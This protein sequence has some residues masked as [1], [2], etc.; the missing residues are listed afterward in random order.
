MHNQTEADSQSILNTSMQ[1]RRTFLK[2]GAVAGAGLLLPLQGVLTRSNAAIP[3][4]SLRPG[5][6]PKYV[7]ALAVPPAMPRAGQLM[8]NGAPVDYYEVAMRQFN[9]HILPPS[10]GIAPTTVWGYGAANAPASFAYP[11]CT[12]EAKANRPVRV[13][14]VNDLIDNKGRFRKHLLAVDQTLHWAN[15]PGGVNGRDGRGSSQLPYT[16]PVPMVPHLHGAH[17]QDHSDGYAEAWFLPAAANVPAGYARNGTWYDYFKARFQQQH[18]VTWA[19]GTA[20]YQYGNDQR[21]TTLWFHDHS[22]G[23]TRTNVYAGPAGFYLLRGGAG[24]AVTGRLPG[25][26]PALGDTQG[27]PHYEIPLVIQDRSFNADSSLFYPDNRAFFEGLTPDQLQIPFIPDPSCSGPSDVSPLWNAEFFGNCMVVNGRTWPFLNVEKRRYRFRILNACNS[28]FLILKLSNG[29]P[30]CQIGA[31]GGFLAAPINRSE[32][33]LG[34]AERADVIVDFTHVPVGAELV[35]MNVAPDEPYGGGTPGVDF[36]PSDPK[37]TGQVM[38]FRVRPARDVDVS[39]PGMDLVLPS[40]APHGAPNAVRQVSLN[41]LESAT[42][43]VIADRRG[44]ILQ[45]CS[46]P[47]AVPFGPTTGQLGIL[48]MDG[49]GIPVMWEEAVTENPALGSTEIWELHNFTEDA[50]PIHLHQTMFEVVNRQG[51]DGSV[52]GPEVWESGLKDTVI[53]YPGEITRVKTFWDIPGRFA[54]HCHILEHEDNEMMRPLHV[55]PIV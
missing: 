44:R 20:T 29:M 23:L 27:Q 16:G 32:L 34:P 36:A 40:R 55:G 21:A 41:E 45:A 3:G 53:A 8:E 47:E 14:W 7:N 24:D 51:G 52:R 11:A 28:R 37:T 18:G 26:A 31:D 39:T 4:G 50:H 46:N 13:K 25:P 54:W 1:N 19:P 15:P 10:M 5:S 35:M 17:V 12:I 43:R 22:L 48:N 9:Q 6:V 33:L 2:T 49:S 42:V 38:M 30:L